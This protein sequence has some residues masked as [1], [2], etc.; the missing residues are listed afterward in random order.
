MYLR[1]YRVFLIAFGALPLHIPV[2]RSYSRSATIRHLRERLTVHYESLIKA[3]IY[4]RRGNESD[5]IE[6]TIKELME[7][8]S[9]L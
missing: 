1:N 4:D 7:T 9:A 2:P 3:S 5:E 8:Y 6:L